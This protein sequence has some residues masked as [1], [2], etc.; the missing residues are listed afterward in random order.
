M[1]DLNR[2]IQQ[3]PPRGLEP[4]NVKNN[5]DKGLGQDDS[6]SAAKSAAFSTENPEI[7]PD[8]AKIIEAW[9]TLPEPIRR[10]MLA[11]IGV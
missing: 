5:H 1:V 9:P 3:L 6:L 7:G 10:A 11:S 2:I 8:L 4:N